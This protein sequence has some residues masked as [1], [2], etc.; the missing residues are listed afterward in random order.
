MSRYTQSNGKAKVTK[1]NFAWVL[2][3]AL[4][5]GEREVGG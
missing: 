1:Q 5:N 4:D 2:E 3:K